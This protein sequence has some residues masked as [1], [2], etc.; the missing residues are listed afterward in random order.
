MMGRLREWASRLWGTLTSRRL[1]R[2]LEEELRQHLEFAA[3][4]A[5]RRGHVSDDDVRAIR[6]RAGG[7]AQAMEAVRAQRGL[8]WLEDAVRDLRFGARLL[9]RGPGFTTVAVLSLA[10]GIGSSSA[11]FSLINAIV[12]RPL[13]V[14]DPQELHIAQAMRAGSRSSCFSRIQSWSAPPSCLPAVPRLPRRAAP[15][16]C[17]SRHEK[18]EVERVH[19]R[20]R[21]CSWWPATSLAPCASVRRSVVCSVPTTIEPSANIPSR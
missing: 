9:V 8:P 6:L 12:L 2:E 1:D 13:P 16:P 3:E 20:L 19:P 10:L 4:D 5:R 15:N 7:I 11:I 17:S 14:A 18:A 21:R